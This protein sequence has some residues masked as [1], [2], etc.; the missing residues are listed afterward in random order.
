MQKA[1]AV[2]LPDHIDYK[3]KILFVGINPGLRS[4]QLGHHYAGHSNRFWK[5]FNEAKYIDT[6]LSYHDDW[7]LPKWG[8][9]LTNIVDRP[10]AKI[11]ELT[12]QD[13]LNGRTR[14]LTKVEHYRPKIMALLSITV[15][16][17]LLLTDPKNS[18]D[19]KKINTSS[20]IG[21]QDYDFGGALVFILPNPSGRNTH[22]SFQDM[23]RLF[24][25]LRRLSQKTL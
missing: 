13:Y 5:L 1:K 9:G 12:D 2:D 20:P 21:L 10:T 17:I 14:L 19:R 7:R 23:L 6:P 22:Y 15:K 8:Y 11:Q 16:N 18:L 4:T 24:R 25:Q 3:L